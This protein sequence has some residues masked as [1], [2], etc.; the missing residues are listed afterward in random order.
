MEKTKK[1]RSLVFVLVASLGFL[2]LCVNT[3][4]SVLIGKLSKSSLIRDDKEDYTYMCTAY[5]LAVENE[6][7]ARMNALSRYVHADIARW[8]SV[9]Q[10]GRW[11]EN[12]T[13]DAESG[14]DYVM[15]CGPDGLAYTTT[16]TRTDIHTRPYFTAI[17][18]DGNSRYIDDPVI[19]K[20][21]GNPVIHITRA[22]EQNGQ[23]IGLVAGVMNLDRVSAITA[24]KF[25][26]GGYGW[27]LA[28]DG[29]VIAHPNA[30]FIMNK[31]F[32]TGLSE[33]FEDM[34][35]V[36]Q[37]IAN[38]N[39]G[40]AVIRG[41][42]GGRD[43]IFYRG[44]E[45]CPWGLALTVPEAQITNI[46]IEIRKVLLACGGLAVAI[47]VLVIGLAIAASLKPLKIVE[48]A[49]TGISAGNADLTQRIEVK[50]N[51][52]IGTVVQGFNN[53]TAKLQSIIADVKSSKEELAIA[54]Q[55][56]NASTEDTASSITQ[57]L[58]SI[59]EVTNQVMNQSAGVEETAGAVNEI[60]SN[61]QS[62][63][64]MIENQS[65]GVTQAS[66]A[67]EEMIGNIAS[68]NKSVDRMAESFQELNENAHTGF[69]K[70][71]D[72]NERIVQIEQQSSM[73]KEAN[74]AISAI[75]E[76]TNL[77]AMNAAI[78]AAHAGEAGKGFSVVADEIR[79]LSETSTMQS[80][81]IGEQLN[82]IQ[83]QINSV[84]SASNESSQ[85]F[86]TVSK[87]IEATDE[88]VNQIK[89]AMQEQNEGSKQISEALHVMNDSTSEVRNASA[90]MAEGNKAILDEVNNLQTA[91]SIIRDSMSQM[92]S[93]AKKISENG[94]ALTEVS[95][96]IQSSINKI[97]AQID[98][99]KV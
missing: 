25:G 47:F 4:Q 97:G 45:G 1:K 71:Q 15:F 80:K 88:L 43:Y 44:I 87:K 98:Q 39:Q 96:Q 20:T 82:K 26:E 89:A 24:I 61:I 8:G 72:V 64:H 29:T 5:T 65:A 57:I 86:E 9:E 6:L 10:I 33:G 3:F 51:N 56:M 2:I 95:T 23:I 17:L 16:G 69:I 91:T 7:E 63:E 50:S 67:V 28:S 59:D 93:G 74:T 53:F 70:Q 31:N 55:N 79:K 76:Q 77:L 52:E 81:T 32:I 94:R 66:A 92:S 41:L 54:G 90:E 34:A 99:F 14:F 37:E 40:N 68:V 83:E 35:A 85:A 42:N 38:H 11:L 27:M 49:I 19:S 21:T 73:L 22:V 60:A 13:V 12:E 75:A 36:A 84:V 58:T 78:E 48:N 18:E 30:E 62:L 46:S